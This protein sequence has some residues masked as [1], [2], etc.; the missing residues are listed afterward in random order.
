ML[1]S[2]VAL[3]FHTVLVLPLI[4]R[5]IKQK[6]NNFVALSKFG[7]EVSSVRRK[8]LLPLSFNL[9]PKKLLCLKIIYKHTYL[10][11]PTCLPTKLCGCAYYFVAVQKYYIVEIQN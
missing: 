8:S 7:N 6:N 10:H 9:P 1:L 3:V 11:M 5:E 4:K 2:V